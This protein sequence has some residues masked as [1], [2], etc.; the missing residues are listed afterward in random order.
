MRVGMGRS[1][2]CS[3]ARLE[4]MRCPTHRRSSLSAVFV[5]AAEHR[6]TKVKQLQRRPQ[7][8]HIAV[9][10]TTR[11]SKHSHVS[12][13]PLS[14]SSIPRTPPS[15]LLSSSIPQSSTPSSSHFRNLLPT[16]S[17]SSR[18]FRS[19]GDREALRREASSKRESRSVTSFARSMILVDNPKR[20]AQ[21]V[22]EEEVA[23]PAARLD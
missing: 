1:G 13:S 22:A 19:S 21:A 17:H 4:W 16:P 15:L 7:R 5:V 23:S 12:Y 8:D 18:S 3:R 14:P 9:K 11:F 6:T 10:D 2:Q 20:A